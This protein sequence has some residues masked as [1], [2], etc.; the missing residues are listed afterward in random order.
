MTNRF[1]D[2]V[3]LITGASGGLGKAIARKFAEQD[4]NLA[5]HYN[6]RREEALSFAAELEEKYG[7]V[8]KAYG[9]NIGN[10]ADVNAMVD[11]IMSDFGTIDILVNNAGISANGVSW[12]LSTQDWEKALNINLTGSFNCIRA[13][14]PVM[15][16]N[17]YGRIIS[18]SSVVG[19]K[20]AAGTIAYSST[21]AGLIGMMKTVAR[22]VAGNNITV[23]CVA[24]GYINAGIIN[25]V[26]QK[27]LEE[28]IIPQIPMKRLGDA[29]DVA[30]SVTFLASDEA[31]YITGVVLPVDGGF[32]F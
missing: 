9:A 4:A 29:E 16:K 21:K 28:N 8:Y 18:I 5:I 20:G 12:K 25:E 19:L 10:E 26:P 22:E 7:V 3:A 11:Q 13:V 6:S 23:N 17:Q 27:L 14:L 24:P 31:K 15:R 1:V 32:S 2:R 30:N